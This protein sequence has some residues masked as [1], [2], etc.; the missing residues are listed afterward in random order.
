WGQTE[1]VEVY[2]MFFSD[3]LEGDILASLQ[4][5]L[6]KIG[7]QLRSVSDVLSVTGPLKLDDWLMDAA[8]RYKEDE[9]PQEATQ[10]PPTEVNTTQSADDTPEES[11]EQVAQKVDNQIDQALT[12]GRERLDIYR[13][14]CLIASGTFG[15]GEYKGV[16]QA[17][18][19]TEQALPS[20]I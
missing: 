10:N 15:P 17:Q 8:A 4:K 3:T 9:E 6:G 5:K 1:Q 20:A 12:E 11:K 7:A 2:H 16:E 14:K 18:R 19:V 13:Q